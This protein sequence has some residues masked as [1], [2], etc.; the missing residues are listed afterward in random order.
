MSFLEL[1]K[2]AQKE[3]D[4]ERA[5]IAQFELSVNER[6]TNLENQIQELERKTGEMNAKMKE[7]QLREET[8]SQ[9]E[10]TVRRDTQVQEDVNSARTF[11][12]NADTARKETQDMK[13]EM[14]MLEADLIRR[15]RN[16]S[17]RESSYR[18]EIRKEIAEKLTGVR[19]S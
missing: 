10:L 3:L 18:E 6:A 9:R 19:L 1:A 5:R 11:Y 17:E 2:E 13:D 8:V 4:G 15:E 16:L 14:K 7:L 12:E